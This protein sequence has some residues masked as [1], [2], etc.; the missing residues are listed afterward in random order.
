MT[1]PTKKVGLEIKE[2][3][4]T[5]LHKGETLM[6][7]KEKLAILQQ[8]YSKAQADLLKIQGAIELLTELIKEGE[9]HG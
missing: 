7:Y 6:T 5:E 1:C 3:D 4:F 9:D 2:T 8:S